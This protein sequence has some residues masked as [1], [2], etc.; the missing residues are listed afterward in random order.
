MPT[1]PARWV[2]NESQYP[3]F[4]HAIKEW[5]V[6]I[7]AYLTELR[8]QIP[9]RI[10]LAAQEFVERGI[11]KI[12]GDTKE[13]YFV[14][15][16]FQFVHQAIHR[17]Y[18]EKYGSALH[19]PDEVF[20]GACEILGSLFRLRVPRNLRRDGEPGKT[21]WIVF[22]IDL[23]D[24]EDP[25]NWLVNPPNLS[26]FESETRRHALDE[27]VSV[28][29]LLR[30][31]H[32]DLMTAKK[33]DDI[34][35]E[36][37]NNISVHLMASAERLTEVHR[38]AFGIAC[39]EAHQT[40]EKSLKLLGRQYR[41]QHRKTHEL[42]Q[43]FRDIQDSVTGIDEDLLQKMP[44]KNRVSEMRAGE[45]TSV[46][47]QVAYQIYRISLDVTAQCTSAMQRDIRARNA[48]FLLK[49]PPWA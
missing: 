39:W 24:E 46:G 12:E 6:I 42:M 48:A 18:K 15:P 22:P 10:M 29:R 44:T 37:D 26:A 40:V 32:N 3:S 23:Q 31:I 30:V 11:V 19:R 36:L 7:D 33:P 38:T 47:P 17:W 41:G 49:M 13:N 4:E 45:G 43:L 5:M 20:L 1:Q 2:V 16:W 9:D 21:V 35:Q 27:V 14:R 34:S 28:A 25:A 8:V